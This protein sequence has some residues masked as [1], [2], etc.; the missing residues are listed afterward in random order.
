M[1]NL[2][3]FPPIEPGPVPRIDGQGQLQN[4]RHGADFADLL[5]AGTMLLAEQFSSG[6]ANLFRLAQLGNIQVPGD[7]AISLIMLSS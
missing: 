6:N 5:L 3:T 2:G 7:S 1:I 4:P